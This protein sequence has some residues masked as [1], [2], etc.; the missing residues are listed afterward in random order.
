MKIP[1][2]A[3]SN[4][5]QPFIQLGNGRLMALSIVSNKDVYWELA[6]KSRRNLSVLQ[7]GAICF[8]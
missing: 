3:V 5:E 6:K 2:Q 1:A 4:N 8:T 7:N